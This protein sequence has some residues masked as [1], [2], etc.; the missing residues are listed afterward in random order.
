VVLLVCRSHSIIVLRSR[1]FQQHAPHFIIRCDLVASSSAADGAAVFSCWPVPQH[2]QQ[3]HWTQVLAKAAAQLSERQLVLPDSQVSQVL[4]V[5]CRFEAAD[6]LHC[7][8]PG[9][10]PSLEPAPHSSLQQQPPGV[11]PAAGKASPGMVWHLPRCSLQFELSASGSVVSLDHRGYQCST[12]QL[13]VS[14]PGQEISYT[15]PEF[16]QYLVLDAQQG[17]SDTVTT[18]QSNRVVLVPSGRVTVQR[19]QPGSSSSSRQEPSIRVQLSD[20]C[21]ESVKV[22][23]MFSAGGLCC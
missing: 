4:R 11:L 22:R 12:Q 23:Q 10:C 2:L 1:D 7:Y 15:L 5:L 16:Q 3:Q 19:Q 18:D 9:A 6:F 14:E 13:L 21:S 20:E 8:M 17:S